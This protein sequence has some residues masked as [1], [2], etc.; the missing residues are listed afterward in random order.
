LFQAGP[1]ISPWY[2]AHGLSLALLA[3][4]GPRYLPL[5]VVGPLVNG[6]LFWIGPQW[7]AVLLGA[8]AITAVY[9]V[10]GTFLYCR[11]L[12]APLSSLRDV[13]LFFG[14]PGEHRRGVAGRRR[15][16]GGRGGAG[17]R[18]ACA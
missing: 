8:L 12:R 5:L 9:G 3:V 1:G 4:F 15:A 18:M 16:G 2:P 17:R 10:A 13:G 7:P 11:R 6:A 14:T